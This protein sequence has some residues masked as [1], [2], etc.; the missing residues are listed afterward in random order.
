MI[1]T[2]LF[3]HAFVA[4]MLLAAFIKLFRI[5]RT[6]SHFKPEEPKDVKDFDT[7]SLQLK[8]VLSKVESAKNIDA[9]S[10][11]LIQELK[12]KQQDLKVDVDKVLANIVGLENSIRSIEDSTKR[13]ENILVGP[14]SKGALGEKII[15]QQLEQLPQDWI[16]RNVPYPDFKKV[17]YAL[18]VPDA[19]IIPIDS[20]WTA[21]ELLDQ[22][23]KTADQR[24]QDK[25]KGL[26]VSEVWRRARE[27]LKYLDKDRTLG[28]CIVAVPDPVFQISWG[29]QTRLLAVNIV[30]ISY[31]LLIPYILTIVKL[32]W[33]SAQSVQALQISHVL[34]RSMAQIQLLQQLIDTDVSSP[35]NAFKQQQVAYN[36]HNDQFKE[37]LANLIQVHSELNA[38]HNS[39]MPAVDPLTEA[40]IASVPGTLKDKLAQL[41]DSLRDGIQNGQDDNH[42]DQ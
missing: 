15:E 13:F 9:S 18:R 33:A 11:L 39:S 24:E 19:R 1:Y 34:N 10:L 14:Q 12:D 31:S 21:T 36:Q 17:E 20:K 25:L 23:G 16:A 27:V 7:A 6:Q 3:V 41:G 22:L 35:L 32:F 5:S 2:D 42:V 8:Q 4:F 40:K 26:I 29:I 28:F 37:A 30:L 38:I